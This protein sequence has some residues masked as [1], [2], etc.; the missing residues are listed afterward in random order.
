MIRVL[1][2]EDEF[3]IE[4]R[5]AALRGEAG[6][7]EVV[8]PSTSVFDGDGYSRDE[9]IGAASAVPFLADR[10]LVIV[11]GL[12]ER[13]DAN[14][15]RSRGGSRG[16]ALRLPGGDWDGLAEGLDA[17]PPTTELI[18]VEG[19]LRRNGA[20]LKA[21]GG[22]AR[23]E[24]F[25]A[26]RGRDLEEWVKRRFEEVGQGAVPAAVRR[27]SDL[28]GGQ[29][30]LL[31]QEI[32]KLVLYAGDRRVDVADVDLMVSPAREANI[33]AAVDAVLE[34][35]PAISLKLLYQLLE[36]GRSVQYILGML[37]RQVRM[38]IV[39]QDM[40]RNGSSQDEI[41]QR[42][43]TK[44]GSYPMRK[45][46]DQARKFP[47]SYLAGIHRR[48]LEADVAFKTG[49]DERIGVEL[50]VARISTAG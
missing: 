4:E 20:G 44:S 45:T 12:L 2:G 6:P 40:T 35:R 42:I 38:V 8:G 30:R 17:L 26:R 41:A 1:H 47:P 11:R 50:L 3:S 46:L 24:V 39:A 25:P 7:P 28:I 37:A 43:G 27:L 32:R 31:D 5:L 49:A 23:V 48:L 36:D 33:F 13:I 9:M 10:R 22:S 19:A 15:G 14:S 34:R 16:N 29:M 21:A 18:F